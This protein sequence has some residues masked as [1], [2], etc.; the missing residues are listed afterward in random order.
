MSAD[1]AGK[2]DTTLD[3]ELLEILAC[4]E[5]K[6]PVNLAPANALS[7]L[8]ERIRAGGVLNRG[9]NS[10]SEEVQAGLVRE[11]GK[12]LYPVRDGIPIMLVDEAIEL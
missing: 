6:E 2:A 7:E 12:W 3:P 5:S 9:G 11:D 10:V 4:P 8:N 1:E